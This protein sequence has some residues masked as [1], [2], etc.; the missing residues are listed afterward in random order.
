MFWNCQE[1]SSLALASF[2]KRLLTT[3]GNSVPSEQAFST[4]NYIYSKTRNRL[5]PERANKLQ[6]IYM[7]SR[8]LVKQ[9][10]SGPTTEELLALKELYRGFQGLE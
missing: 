2:A 10:I 7:N 3:I 6:Y 8:T 1:M 4:M 5:S 9:N